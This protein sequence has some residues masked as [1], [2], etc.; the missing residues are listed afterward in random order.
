MALRYSTRTQ[1]SSSPFRSASP[2]PQVI[3]KGI[4]SIVITIAME[5]KVKP[6]A[7]IRQP[8]RGGE[9][10]FAKL[11]HALCPSFSINIYL[12]FS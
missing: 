10:V 2:S 12:F 5:G 7:G 3:M 4:K 9:V 11:L 6:E 8:L 1:D